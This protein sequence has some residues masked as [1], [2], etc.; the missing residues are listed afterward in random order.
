MN[1]AEG[2]AG[3]EERLLHEAESF[4]H[5]VEGLRTHISPA[6]I[7]GHG[8]ERLLMRA[9]ELPVTFG[10][11]PFGFELPLHETEPNADF[12]VSLIGGSRSA[13]FIEEAA[14]S[15][16]ASPVTVG[17]AH[18]LSAMEQEGSALR[19]VAGRKILLEFDIDRAAQGDSA[20][21]GI[22][23]Y[24]ETQTLIG[25][26]RR[27]GDVN[28][29]LEAVCAAAGW[30]LT[31]PE[32]REAERVYFALIPATGVRSVGTFPARARSIRLAM[33]GFRTAGEVEAF[34]KQAG[35]PGDR[36]AA[37]AVV[38][39]LEQLEAFAHMGVHFD[40]GENGVGPKLGL[41]CFARETE[42][43]KDVRHWSALF[44]ALRE[45]PIVVRE[46]LSALADT[47][48][49]AEVL[50]GRSGAIT[51]LRGIHHIKLVLTE[52]RLEQVKA[53]VFLLLMSMPR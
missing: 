35:W 53:Y 19:S 49:G 4:G 23:L 48:S 22:F 38:T 52:N 30:T 12:G 50:F 25:D 29:M 42:W 11:F 31:D 34:L 14:R 43:L 51:L 7:G 18:L 13:A 45:E 16:G 28:V 46:K 36:A 5:M 6:L 2:L 40:I 32:R 8:W 41:S 17:I 26:G 27:F 1:V 39:R 24:P 9:R 47:S 3:S 10:A 15:P 33:T 37:T 21:P 44:D 20:D